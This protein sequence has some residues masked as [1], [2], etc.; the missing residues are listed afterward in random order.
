M[1]HKDDGDVWLPYAVFVIRLHRPY[2]GI[3]EG[4]PGLP[5]SLSARTQGA[6]E[7]EPGRHCLPGGRPVLLRSTGDAAKIGALRPR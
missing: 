2:E 7:L 3:G 6:N 1:S 4:S 5:S